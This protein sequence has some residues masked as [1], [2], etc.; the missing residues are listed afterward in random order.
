M[1]EQG[2]TAHVARS[3]KYITLALRKL[4]LEHKI[5]LYTN[6]NTLRSLH[7]VLYVLVVLKGVRSFVI[8]D[9]NVAGTTSLRRSEFLNRSKE[10]RRLLRSIFP[11]VLFVL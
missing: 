1:S 6:T 4:R 8:D 9:I 5:N 11:T 10:D 7:N 2:H 3:C